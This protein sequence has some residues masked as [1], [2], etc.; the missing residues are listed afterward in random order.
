L[1]QAY[2]TLEFVEA[3]P[4]DATPVDW[5]S[6]NLEIVGVRVQ[7]AIVHPNEEIHIDFY[8][9]GNHSNNPA[10]LITAVDSIQVMRLDHTEIY[11][12]MAD[13]RYLPA[14]QIYH[15]PITLQ[16]GDP[17]TVLPPRIIT[18]LFEWVNL[19]DDVALVFDSGKSLLEIQGASFSD[20][21][22]TA[23]SLNPISANY[24]EIDLESFQIP[25]SANAGETINLSF[26]WNAP[27]DIVHDWTLTM[28]LFDAEGELLSQSDGVMWWYPSSTW[29]NNLAFEDSRR[30]E[31]PAD[32][33]A[34]DYEIRIG[35]YREK[36]GQFIRMAVTEG[37]SIDNLL[38][39]P[40]SLHI[41]G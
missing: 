37:E 16:I 32:L 1:P 7:E 11:P 31:I 30:L 36:N 3:L 21:S 17:E 39:L 14:N 29:I 2:P 19:E 34:G 25:E 27:Q 28:Q 12:A 15:V 13:M 38:V 8:F 22:Y 24:A 35:W 9:R 41:D 33:A 4:E 5:T 40:F 18:I 6:G 26:V 20:P 23:P 10:L